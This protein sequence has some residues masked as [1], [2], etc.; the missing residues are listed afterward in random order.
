MSQRHWQIR[1][2][3]PRDQHAARR[4]V[5]DGLGEHFGSIDETRNPD[6]DDIWTHYIAQGD[7]FVV[8]EAG[9]ALIGTGAMRAEAGHLGDQRGRIVRVSV[10]PVYRR[11]GIGRTIVA[12]LVQ[13][14]CQRG[15]SRLLVETNHD[16][17]AAI[18]LYQ[19]C[20]FQPYDRDEESVH[21][22]LALR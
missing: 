13:V 8:V 19:R 14:A 10:A 1:P 18:G 15:L 12:H 5:L 6:L 22:A 7:L 20:G 9:V 16:W 17:V 2:F 3:T 4:L 21:L 11:Y